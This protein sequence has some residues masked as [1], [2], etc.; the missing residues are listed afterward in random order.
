MKKASNDWLDRVRGLPLPLKILGVILTVVLGLALVQA[1]GTVLVLLSLALWL[2][3]LA[4]LL[5]EAGLLPA[6]VAE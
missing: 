5:R 6:P 4:T 3:V 2:V 1:L